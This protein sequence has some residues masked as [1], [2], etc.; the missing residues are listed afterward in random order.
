M[1]K[2]CIPQRSQGAQLC[3]KARPVVPSPVGHRD[4]NRSLKMTGLNV[5]TEIVSSET[6][7]RHF[8]QDTT[9]VL[10]IDNRQPNNARQ[11]YTRRNPQTTPSWG[12]TNCTE[13]FQRNSNLV[14]PCS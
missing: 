10:P 14:A 11:I 13:C 8:P 12:V 9:T 1:I 3:Q 7:T 5:N 6:V 4:H 2:G